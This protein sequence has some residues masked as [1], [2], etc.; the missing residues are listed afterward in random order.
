MLKPIEAHSATRTNYSRFLEAK[1][2]RI[3]KTAAPPDDTPEIE[4]EEFGFNEGFE[5]MG[6]EFYDDSEFGYL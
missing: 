1:I 5:P 2:E 4:V 6:N 3:L